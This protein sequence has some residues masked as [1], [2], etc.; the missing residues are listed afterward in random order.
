M[1]LNNLQSTYDGVVVKTPIRCKVIQISPVHTYKK[2]NYDMALLEGVLADTTG[3]K[4]FKCYGKN[5]FPFLKEGSS[6]LLMNVISKPKDVIIRT[7]SRVC[8]A[9]KL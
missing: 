1:P 2:D 9:G 8:L 5:H 3:H 7:N 4:T 6:V